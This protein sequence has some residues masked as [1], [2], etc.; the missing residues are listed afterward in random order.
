M[1]SSLRSV[2]GR[3]W[4]SGA[5]SATRG[6]PRSSKGD[7]RLDQ[8]D[9][10]LKGGTRGPA[11]VAGRVQDSRLIAAVRYPNKDLQMPPNR[12]LDPREVS[13]LEEWV[14]RGLPWAQERPDVGPTLL[15]MEAVRWGSR[16]IWRATRSG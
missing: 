7:L 10:V 11:A 6:R 13:V 8:R 1:W 16:R 3:S 2:C 5:T 4:L 12:R 15:S 14:R 9:R